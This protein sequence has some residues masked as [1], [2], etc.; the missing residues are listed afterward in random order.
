MQNQ[1]TL[2]LRTKSTK[3]LL[4]LV[5]SLV[6]VAAG[7]LTFKGEIM[8]W[9]VIIFFGLGS[10]VFALQLFSNASSLQL[11]SEGFTVRSLFRSHS[12]RWSDVEGFAVGRMGN[13]KHEG[14]GLAL[15]VAGAFIPGAMN[16]RGI[17]TV[18]FNFSPSYQNKHALRKINKG[19]SGYEACLPDTYGMSAE[20]LAELMKEWQRRFSSP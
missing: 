11:S 14:A 8:S 20:N 16:P 13:I 17:K 18:V 3:W 7:V 10:V 4:Y 15:D 1:D 9:L 5:I 6:F 2:T 12:Y 19:L